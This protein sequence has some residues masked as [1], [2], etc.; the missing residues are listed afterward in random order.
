MQKIICVTALWM[1]AMTA[2]FSHASEQNE[3]HKMEE[4]TVTATKTEVSDDTVP[5]TSHTVD[6][7]T[8]DTQPDFYMSNVGEIVRDVPGVHVGQYFPWGPPWIHLRGT[9]Y[10][11]GRTI[12]LVDGLPVASFMAS[13]LNP[14]DVERADILLGPSSALYGAN[15]SGGA[16]NFI[17]RKGSA[18]MGAKAELS[19]G[20]NNTFRPH[21]SVGDKTEDFA[22]Y[23]SY[24]GDYSDGYKMKPV[25]DMLT[26]YNLGKKQYITEAT[27]EEND[28]KNT[29]LSSKF[30]WK[31]SNGT[32]LW[33]GVN[34]TQRYLYGGQTNLILDDYG[35]QVI[36]TLG[37]ETPLSHWGKV[38]F[39][40]A[41]QYYDHPQQ[42]NNGLSVK[43]NQTV[44]DSTVIRQYDWSIE[45]FPAEFQTD[46]YLGKSN[47]LTAG[48]FWCRESEKRSNYY[49]ATDKTSDSEWTT[50]QTAFYLQDQMFFMDEKLSVLGGVRYDYWKYFDIFD[51]GSTNQQPDSVDKDHVTYRGGV[52]YRIN[53]NIALRTSAGTAYWPGT[54]L[55][56]F[57]NIST[58]KTQR[59][60][61]P[62]LKPEKTWMADMGTDIAF[63]QWGTAF[64]ITAY[65]GE[66][67]DI[68]SYRYDENPDLEGGSIIRSQNLGGADIYGLEIGVKQRLF[69]ERLRFTASLTFNH[70]EI[71]DDPANSG[72]QL[73]NAP[74][75][76]GSVGL[77][78]MN[79][80]MLN[81]DLL[82][83]F[84]DDRYYDD[85]NTELP[86]F[87]MKSYETLDAKIWRDWKIANNVM[88]TTSLS[89]V[90]IFDREYETEIVYIN[91]GRYI[92]ASA[93]VKYV[94]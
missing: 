82:F 62:D 92:E 64:N 56:F 12:Y 77:A 5:F 37:F 57:Q 19:Y 13:T 11:I 52:K 93:G 69:S 38:K 14:R 63:P 66:I 86:Y 28:Y 90:N 7:E 89:A 49:P 25:E 65:Y 51:A 2:C 87:H 10:F 54:A 45:R 21:V 72:H 58:G 73:R 75:Y 41:Y 16:V 55:W 50:D 32:G 70:S 6:R 26:L 18:D 43:D 48:A 44:L 59:E 24:S 8:L 31:N 17:T 61:N 20:S 30:N 1:L 88:L 46:F 83:R 35:D 4:I 29:Y 22:Y 68:V 36:S 34:Y 60:A 53:E 91:P 74:D 40:G 94:F 71:T 80:E 79:P 76:W 85:E 9:G 81:A 3:I 23:L 27:P 84:S 42:Y 39:T 15:A 78:Y 47:I 67:K 33:L